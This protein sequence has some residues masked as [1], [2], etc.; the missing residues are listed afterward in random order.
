MSIALESSNANDDRRRELPGFAHRS[1]ACAPPIYYSTEFITVD[2][3]F[4]AA[5]QLMAEDHTTSLSSSS[6]SSIG[7]NSD[8]ST[9]VGGDG[10]E[11][12]SEYNGGPLGRLNALE[13]VLP[14]KYVLFL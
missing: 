13:E 11:V 6:T 3:R 14:V 2:Q 10:E 7:K 12:Q 5:Q 1:M 9:G 8:E 4:P